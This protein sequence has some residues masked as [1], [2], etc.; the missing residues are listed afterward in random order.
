MWAKSLTKLVTEQQSNFSFNQGKNNFILPKT[1]KV[2]VQNSLIISF[3]ETKLKKNFALICTKIFK[4][5]DLP[6]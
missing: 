6:G 3:L 4:S 5:S 2:E 1:E